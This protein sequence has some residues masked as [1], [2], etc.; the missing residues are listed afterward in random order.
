[1]GGP[2]A[3]FT[4][5][6]DDILSW[7]RSNRLQLNADKKKLIWCSTSSWLKQLQATSI[8]VG[9]VIIVGCVAA[10]CQIHSVHQLLSSTVLP[11]LV[12]LYLLSRLD[13]MLAVELKMGQARSI[14]R[15]YSRFAR[16]R[17]PDFFKPKTRLFKRPPKPMFLG[18]AFFTFFTVL[19]YC[20]LRQFI[21]KL[22][23][24]DDNIA[25]DSDSLKPL[26]TTIS[27]FIA[28]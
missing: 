3:R 12:V 24:K 21:S 1:M 18:L 10:L 14:L 26:S 9:S 20:Y 8:K 11:S 5:C 13:Y 15:Q 17:K 28:T 25:D 2:A 4:A 16:T 6:T 22:I 23:K 7:M 27:M 19:F